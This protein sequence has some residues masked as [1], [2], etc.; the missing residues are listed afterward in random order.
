M[1]LIVVVVA[2]ILI[3]EG[4]PYLAVP[5][6]VKRWS[7]TIQE[8]PDRSLR[9]VGLICMVAGLTLLYLVKVLLK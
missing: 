5:A 7:M 9:L 6:K 8:L 1:E 2:V 4:V 3:I